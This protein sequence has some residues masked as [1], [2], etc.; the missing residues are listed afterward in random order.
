MLQSFHK[1]LFFIVVWSAKCFYFNYPTTPIS[2]NNKYL[3][4]ICSHKNSTLIFSYISYR[5]FLS[6][7][8]KNKL[9]LF[10][11][12]YIFD[13]K[14]EVKWKN[15]YF[16]IDIIIIKAIKLRWKVRTYKMC[17]NFI[18]ILYCLMNIKTN[19]YSNQQV[20]FIIVIKN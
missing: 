4:C 18:T 19:G 10:H 6:A 1:Y 14:W 11:N 13:F 3:Y 8:I 20:V 17:T 9:S 16:W 2:N 12:I 7:H 5:L 15:T